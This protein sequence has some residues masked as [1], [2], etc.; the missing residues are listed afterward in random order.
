MSTRDNS[1]KKEFLKLFS[2][3]LRETAPAYF[4]RKRDPLVESM[5]FSDEELQEIE[6]DLKKILL[7]E[8]NSDENPEA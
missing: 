8:V 3:K 4:D 6:E 7:S 2:T 5:E 1:L